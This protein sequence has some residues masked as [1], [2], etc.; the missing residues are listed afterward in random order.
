VGVVEKTSAKKLL[1]FLNDIEP[2][3][4][5]PACPCNSFVGDAALRVKIDIVKSFEM[6]SDDAFAE[7]VISLEE[8]LKLKAPLEAYVKLVDVTV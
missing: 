1:V 2:P 5:N 3:V 8:P 4:P 6:P 7:A